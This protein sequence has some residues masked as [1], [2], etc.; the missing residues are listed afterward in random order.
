[1]DRSDD[2]KL[3]ADTAWLGDPDVQAV[4]DAIRAKGAAIYF[5][6]GCV[7]DALLHVQG[8]DVDLAT[9]ALPQ[10]VIT[11]AQDAGLRAVPTG[12]DHGTIT[13]VSGG[14]GYEVTT[15]RADVETDGRHATVRFS[16]D[17]A[18]DARRR[19]FTMNA[20]YALPDGAIVDPL[21]GV[22]DCLAR[23]VRFIENAHQ[24]IAEDYLRILRYFRFHAWYAPEGAGFDPDAL[25]AIASNSSGLETLSAERVGSEMRKLLAAP[26]PAAAIA[27]MRQTGCLALVLPGAD[28]RF[29]GPVVHL[30]QH[31]SSQPDAILRLTALGGADPVSRLRLSRADAKLLEAMVTH[32][33]GATPLREVAYRQGVRI[34]RGAAVLRAAMAEQ[35]ISEQE[36]ATI[37]KASKMRFPVA[38]SDLMPQL[39]GKELGDALRVLE[40]RWIASDFTLSR[41][42]LLKNI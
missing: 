18:E 2:I 6:G 30:E 41:D 1:M 3:P 27:A 13:V 24:R 19:D 14:K 37:M 26:D 34:A 33:F 36:I 9:D 35:P 11:L 17:I 4:C 25:D 40:A 22:A 21:G 31:V 10:Q 12:I 39:K 42:D 23:H 29:L 32:G 20:L 7:R 16:G 28:D 5:V 15:F 38:A 8:S